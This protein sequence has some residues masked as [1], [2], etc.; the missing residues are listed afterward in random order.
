MQ[1]L[2][3]RIILEGT[4]LPGEVLKVDNFLNHQIDVAFLDEMGRAF[5]EL[6]P[7]CHRA[8]KVLTVEAS[9]IAIAMPVAR[10][11][12]VPLVFAKK[13]K[14]SNID[15]SYYVSNVRSYTY[16]KHY[17]IILSKKYMTHTDHVLIIDDFLARG[18][19][20][21]GLIDLVNQAG[22]SLIGAGVAIEKGFQPGGRKLREKGYDV[23]A[24]ATIA[25]FEN[26]SVRFSEE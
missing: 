15:D 26:G 5:L 4:V 19:A 14:S 21:S 23:R 18:E 10:L 13:A 8:T 7:D 9:G 22:A 12:S 6:F 16:D 3:D 1:A 17:Q 24:L 25:A 20:L 2:K 11:L